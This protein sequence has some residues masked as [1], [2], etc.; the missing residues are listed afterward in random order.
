MAAIPE[1]IV[2]EQNRPNKPKSTVFDMEKIISPF[3][4]EQ[5]NKSAFFL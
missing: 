5:R 3:K 4:R 1:R 2:L